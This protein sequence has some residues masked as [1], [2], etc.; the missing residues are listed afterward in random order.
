MSI[1]KGQTVIDRCTNTI[2]TIASHKTKL[3]DEFWVTYYLLDGVPL[4][5]DYPTRWR[6]SFEISIDLDRRWQKN[7]IARFAR[8]RS[9]GTPDEGE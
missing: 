5:A 8:E 2:A 6:N 7:R 9:L 3:R 1:R 4:T